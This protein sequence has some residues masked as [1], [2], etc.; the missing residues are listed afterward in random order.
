MFLDTFPRLK[1]LQVILLY[2]SLPVSERD[3]KKCHNG[4][5]ATIASKRPQVLAL[6]YIGVK[7]LFPDRLHMKLEEQNIQCSKT[8]KQK[9]NDLQNNIQ[10][11]TNIVKRNPQH[12]VVGLKDKECLL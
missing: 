10:K 8:N 12:F 9:D 4:R 7:Y 6:S 2:R 11:T 1:F 5:I 3:A